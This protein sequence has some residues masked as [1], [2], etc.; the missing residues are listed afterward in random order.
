M[1]C[2]DR[3]LGPYVLGIQRVRIGTTLGDTGLRCGR[4]RLRR[5]LLHH[6]HYTILG[7]ENILGGGIICLQGEERDFPNIVEM[8]TS[9]ANPWN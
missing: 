9:F 1:D 4:N 8:T 6:A 7:A 2:R 3:Y 5:V